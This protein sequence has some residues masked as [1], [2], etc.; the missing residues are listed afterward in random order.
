MDLMR[1]L[2]CHVDVPDY[3]EVII[4]VDN[5]TMPNN[6]LCSSFISEY[7]F[8]H[9]LTIHENYV[10]YSRTHIKTIVVLLINKLFR[11]T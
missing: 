5:P 1:Y 10:F 11:Q 8:F 6:F 7:L 3:L 9:V 4:R 2:H